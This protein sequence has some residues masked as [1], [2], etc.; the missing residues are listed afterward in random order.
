MKVTMVTDLAMADARPRKCACDFVQRVLGCEYMSQNIP[1]NICQAMLA[2]LQRG[3]HPVGA[4]QQVR[5]PKINIALSNGLGLELRNLVVTSQ[6]E[7]HFRY[8]AAHHADPA[9]IPVLDRLR[10]FS[11]L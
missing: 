3:E 1:V 7:M 2:P 6:G 8:P 5:S 10:T 11:Y 9:E 4:S